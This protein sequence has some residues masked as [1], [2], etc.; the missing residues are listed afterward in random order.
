MRDER[1]CDSFEKELIIKKKLVNTK[2]AEALK[3]LGFKEPCMAVY[4]CDIL[5][6]EAIG[7]TSFVNGKDSWVSAPLKTDVIDW[8]AEK[9]QYEAV[10]QKASKYEWYKYTIYKLTTIGKSFATCDERFS[11]KIDAENACINRLI[12]LANCR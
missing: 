12:E 3:A 2:Q 11:N 5:T 7:K 6:F 10:I 8:F 4:I 1:N 9:Y